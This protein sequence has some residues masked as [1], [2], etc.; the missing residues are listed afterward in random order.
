MSDEFK[1]LQELMAIF[2][3]LSEVNRNQL[4]AITRAIHTTQMNT[5]KSTKKEKESATEV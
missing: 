3:E 1:S 2:H 4:M 5:K